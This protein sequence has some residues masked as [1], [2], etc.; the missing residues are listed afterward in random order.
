MGKV[1]RELENPRL[2]GCA[3]SQRP[4]G[5]SL[6]NWEMQGDFGKLQGKRRF[7]PAESP[8][9]LNALK[10]PLPNLTSREKLNHCREGADTESTTSALAHQSGHAHSRHPT[11]IGSDASPA[12]VL[13]HWGT[14]THRSRYVVSQ[15]RRVAALAPWLGPALTTPARESQ[16]GAGPLYGTSLPSVRFLIASWDL[17]V[18]VQWSGQFSRWGRDPPP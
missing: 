16:S 3:G 2:G 7:S 13:G 6:K 15:S 10:S 14:S 4:T 17:Q 5:L 1:G 9:H 11:S 12:T 8:N 18:W